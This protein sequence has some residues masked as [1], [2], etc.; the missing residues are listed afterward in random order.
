M[1]RSMLMIGVMP[2]PALMNS[3]FAGNGSGSVN[4]P[5]TPP[6]LTITPGRAVRT[7]YGE[8]L[9]VP[10]SF[11]VMLM[12]PSGR[13]GSQVIEYARQWWMPST[14]MPTRRYWPGLCPGHFQPGLITTVT[15]SDVSRSMRSIRPRSS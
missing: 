2:L 9:P 14:G 11:G 1:L 15:V 7:R 8:T 13:A 10:S 5:S 3:I 12:Q 4:A 6:S